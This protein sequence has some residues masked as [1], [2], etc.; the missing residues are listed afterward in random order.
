MHGVH[1]AIYFH[2]FNAQ[3]ANALGQ[4]RDGTAQGIF[5]HGILRPGRCGPITLHPRHE[6]HHSPNIHLR[7]H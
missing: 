2:R 6:T 7:F 5:R 4:R 3:P 1:P